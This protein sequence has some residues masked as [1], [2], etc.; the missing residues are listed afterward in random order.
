MRPPSP[1]P[2]RLNAG[3]TL[4]SEGCLRPSLRWLRALACPRRRPVALPH[5]ARSSSV[6]SDPFPS[7][8]SSQGARASAADVAAV[9]RCRRIGE[10][11][12]G[13]LSGGAGARP[14][15]AA[16]QALVADLAADQQQLV[17]PLKDLVARPAFLALIDQA[18]RGTALLQRDALL[19][20]LGATFAPAVMASLTPLLNGFL[21]L[22]DSTS[23]PPAVAAAPPSA[24]PSMPPAASPPPETAVPPATTASFNAAAESV[25]ASAVA[26]ADPQPVSSGVRSMPADASA[27]RSVA[28]RPAAPALQPLVLLLSTLCGALL[29]L[30]VVM[31]RQSGL[32]CSSF[33]I[34]PPQSVT[35]APGEPAALTAAR[36]AEQ[37]LRTA[38]SLADFQ[39]ALQ[40][41]EQQ[42]LGLS[43][44]R[45]TPEQQRQWQE[46]QAVAL[47]GRSRLSR[48]ADDQA[49]L[50]RAAAALQ[51]ARSSVSPEQMAPE[52]TKARA[53]L[54][55][56]AA[57]GFAATAARR[58][59]QELQQLE[60]VAGGAAPDATPAP[61]D[62]T[63]P[64][65]NPDA[66][67]DAAP[68][69]QPAQPA[70]PPQVTPPP[71]PDAPRAPQ[72]GPG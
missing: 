56:I 41:L 31:A 24:W 54:E 50:E 5:S 18:G 44:D 8:S 2:V 39:A 6:S 58:Q 62:G 43:P 33:G 42:L 37:R 59:L 63:D 64:G 9:A 66:G 15:A 48:E 69:P 65:R 57:D 30:A 36:A 28:P 3:G 34:C 25:V 19:A 14:A 29:V 60:Q 52:L 17:L 49:R 72:G 38:T 12:A 11:L 46:L 51:A 67:A 7:A 53:E 70:A 13:Y 10:Q 35:P 68:S 21:G 20:E 22:A 16:L 1:G 71:V 27:L 40:A 32:L 4:R 45:L 47:Q 61:G 55:A 23:P 26:A